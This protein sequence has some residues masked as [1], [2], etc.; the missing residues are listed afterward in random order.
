MFPRLLAEIEQ[1]VPHKF[2]EVNQAYNSFKSGR[3]QKE[4][5]LRFLRNYIGDQTLTAAAK[6]L[7]GC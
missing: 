3:I 6:K 1:L 7:R 2:D 4:V 5:F